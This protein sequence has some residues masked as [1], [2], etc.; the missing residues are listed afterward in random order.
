MPNLP[1]PSADPPDGLAASVGRLTRLGRKRAGALPGLTVPVDA[2]VARHSVDLL[3]TRLREDPRDLRRLVQLAEALAATRRDLRR[4]AQARAVADPVSLLVRV[5][6]GRA[7]QLGEPGQ[8]PPA[9]QLL[10][11]AFALGQAR[12]R[13]GEG[14]ATTLHV[15]ARVYLARGMPAEALRLTTAALRLSSDER[16]ELLVTAARALQ[17]LKRREDAEHAARRAVEHG[18]TLGYVVLARLRATDPSGLTN[19]PRARLDAWVELRRKVRLDDRIRYSGAAR[20]PG[21]VARATRAA[22]WR[23]VAVTVGDAVDLATRATKERK[24]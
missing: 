24:P 4:W 18:S 23:K 20:S 10:R 1:R 6:V 9:E 2:V 11:R 13:G 12:V 7:A 21:E 16:A 15:L 14:D 19:A 22:Q 5:A 3:A 17:Q 8:E